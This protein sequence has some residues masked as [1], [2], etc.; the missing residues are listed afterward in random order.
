MSFIN[1]DSLHIFEMKTA[2][3]Y[4]SLIKGNRCIM[5]KQQSLCINKKELEELSYQI[6]F[7][8]EQ[9]LSDFHELK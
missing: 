8:D 6:C 3:M 4:F 7:D 1:K 9:I 5:V 2:V